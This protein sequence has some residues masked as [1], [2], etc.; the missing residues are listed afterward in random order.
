MLI[1]NLKPWLFFTYKLDIKKYK[2]NGRVRQKR[3]YSESGLLS[4]QHGTQMYAA[5]SKFK[6]SLICAFIWYK[7]L[8]KRLEQLLNAEKI[9]ILGP[10]V[11]NIESN[12]SLNIL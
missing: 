1:I 12:L 4:A 10:K 11:P 5:L 6:L 8:K 9:D 3:K 2:C 7:G